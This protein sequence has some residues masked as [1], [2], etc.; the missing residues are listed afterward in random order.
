VGKRFESVVMPK[1][2][3]FNRGAKWSLTRLY[4]ITIT[5]L[6]KLAL[7]GTLSIV[8]EEPSSWTPGR[9]QNRCWI[10]CSEMDGAWRCTVQLVISCLF[11][12]T[13]LDANARLLWPRVSVW[14]HYQH[15]HSFCP[16]LETFVDRRRI[17]IFSLS[18]KR[19]SLN[20]ILTFLLSLCFGS[21][22]TFGIISRTLVLLGQ[23]S[24]HFFWPADCS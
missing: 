1:I 15:G 16:S 7:A 11:L 13:I 14:W 8:L 24:L 23:E 3:K 17:Y 22:I 20:L 4:F 21:L 12:G 10:I 18:E 9:S 6:L 2:S 5:S 19:I